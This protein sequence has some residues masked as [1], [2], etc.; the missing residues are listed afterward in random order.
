M[1]DFLDH[2]VVL[3]SCLLVCVNMAVCYSVGANYCTGSACV[4]IKTPAGWNSQS[5]W[6]TYD[7][8]FF[9]CFALNVAC[10]SSL[11]NKH[12][13][14]VWWRDVTLEIDSLGT[15]TIVGTHHF[16]V[17]VYSHR[18]TRTH[19]LLFCKIEF[20]KTGFKVGLSRLA[21]LFILIQSS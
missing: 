19:T 21:A 17:I 9:F 16:S 6:K 20:G 13:L 2:T 3:L 18:Q 11:E 14:P 5:K 10:L 15:V 4:G 7:C 8:F 12:R 1:Y